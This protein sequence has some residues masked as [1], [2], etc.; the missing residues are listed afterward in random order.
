M[1]SKQ[2]KGHLY[3]TLL[4]LSILPLVIVGFIITFFSYRTFTRSMYTEVEQ[5]LKNTSE[6]VVSFYDY[7]YPGDYKLVGDKAYELMKGDQVLTRDYSIIDTIKAE[8]GMDITLFYYDTRILTTIQNDSGQ[9]IVGTGASKKIIDDVLEGNTPHFYTNVSINGKTYFAYYAPLHNSDGSIVGM[10]YAGKP[11]SA[12]THTVQSAVSPILI[13]AVVA[14]LLVSV[15]SYTYTNSLVAALKQIRQFL[16]QIAGSNLAAE[17]D[18]TVL[19]R[20]DEL[21][22]M[23]RSAMHMQRSLRTLVEEDILTTLHNRRF[24]DQKLKQLYETS[25]NNHAS[26]TLAIGDIDFFKKFNDTYGH[27]CGDIVLQQ[28]A[29]CLKHA[30]AGKGFAARWG[31][32]EFLLVYDTMEYDSAITCLENLQNEIRNIEVIYEGQRLHITM[33]IGVADS[34][35]H[36][37]I[38]QLLRDADE[39]LYHGKTNGR[40]CIVS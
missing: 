14:V 38:K 25:T 23:A 18:R 29:L 39:K 26:F 21:S 13:T 17:M 32:E 2:K 33:T 16:S 35:A 24:G 40:N 36:A 27:D 22:D 15:F 28:V 10:I 34:G 4:A 6:M 20:N 7:M 9:R 19:C 37:G 3:H 1:G 30:M 31:G 11:R 12:I 5:G 8:T